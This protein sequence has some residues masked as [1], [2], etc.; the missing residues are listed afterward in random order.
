MK[1][2]SVSKT[3]EKKLTLKIKKLDARSTSSRATW[4]TCKTDCLCAR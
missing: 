4:F 3:S 1:N 2:S